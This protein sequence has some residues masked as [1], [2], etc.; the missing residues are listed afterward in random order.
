M[1]VQELRQK[2][3]AA[4]DA[5]TEIVNAAIAE[6]RA[7]TDEEQAKVDGYKAEAKRLDATIDQ[8][9]EVMGMSK[10][11]EKPSAS[12]VSRVPALAGPVPDM[13]T[14]NESGFKS[15]GEFLS[16]I[17]F[18]RFDDRLQALQKMDDGPSGGYNVPRE[19]I[20]DLLMVS[21][22][23][24][25]VRP[26][27]TVIPAGQSPDA[28]VDMPALDQ[29][30]ESNMYGGVTVEWIAEGAQKPETAAKFKQIQLT[31]SEV[32]AHIPVTDKLLR[33]WSAAEM[34]L[35]NLLRRALIAAEDDAFIAGDGSGKPLGFLH[36][37]TTA[38]IDVPRQVANAIS[39]DDILAMEEA[40]KGQ[41]ALWV[42]SRKAKTAL[43]LIKDDNG[44][45]LFRGPRDGF[46]ATL[47]GSP[48]I[49][50][51]AMP[52]LGQLGDLVLVDLSYY[53]IKDGFGIAVDISQHERFSRNQTVIKAFTNVDG[54]V[55]LTEPLITRGGDTVSPF[56][57]LDVPSG[58]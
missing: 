21:D 17:R 55:W 6:G 51:D 23:E 56:V 15:L 14:Q 48:L 45:P 30:A 4:I 3:A 46:P 13:K 43:S 10:S 37:N 47:G 28:G 9:V 54:K 2:R 11:L 26:R 35:T 22:D 1:N 38:R 25:L 44:Q 52:Q 31:P 41:N 57:A 53:L 18:N 16:T 8:A 7:L 27:A 58:G 19:F 29:G 5:A 34:V 20:S 39:Y 49:M 24:A 36:A 42:C 32:A 40:F 50:H 12:P 33:N